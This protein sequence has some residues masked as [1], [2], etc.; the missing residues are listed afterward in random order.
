MAKMKTLETYFSPRER[1][2]VWLLFSK[3][4]NTANDREEEQ[5]DDIWTALGLEAIQRRVD[6]SRSNFEPRDFAGRPDEPDDEEGLDDVGE[7][8]DSNDVPEPD[9]AAAPASSDV[10]ASSPAAPNARGMRRCEL[11]K[12]ELANLIKWLNAPKPAAVG[13]LTLPI[14]RRLE[15]ERDKKGMRAVKA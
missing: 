11:D 7:L 4:I 1:F 14:R 10:A 9:V 12:D 3:Y 6:L 5:L 2:A 8:E 13:R 15:A